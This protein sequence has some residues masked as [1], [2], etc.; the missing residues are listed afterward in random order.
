MDHA[1]ISIRPATTADDLE[2]VWQMWKE[3]MDQKIY[4]PY[5]DSYSKEQIEAV[6]INLRNPI[7][8]AE[9]DGSIVGAY[10]LRPN[11]PAYG[12]HIANAAYMVSSRARGQG[13][14][15]LLCEHSI[16]AGRKLGYR[17][18]QF[19]LVVSTNTAAIRIWEAH[20]FQLI[21]TVP[22]GFRHHIAGFVDAH[23]FF[24]SL[25]ED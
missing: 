20:G 22:G 1:T 18:M 9:I 16:Q 23:I 10:I 11:Q 19:N 24:R 7:Y 15:S 12:D 8:V 2:V 17:G 21:G 4:F 25:L 6:W 14:G 3:V 13:I 5:D